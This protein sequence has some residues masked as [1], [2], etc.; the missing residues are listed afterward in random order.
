MPILNY[1]T[2]VNYNKTIGEIQEILVKS[3]ANKIIVDYQQS[4][5]VGL[6]FHI[7]EQSHPIFFSL[8]CNYQGVL[9]S[10]I[11]NPKVPKKLKTEE[12]AMRV[13]W[14]I[15]KDWIQA[16]LA[17]VEAELATVTEVFLP[18]AITKNGVTLYN[19]LKEDK[20]LLLNSPL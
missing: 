14:R 12:Q 16:Q 15:L 6:T 5:P 9:N 19:Y 11:K 17:I 8:P 1:T 2:G 10:L 13:G 7:I 18:Y 3:G 4:L 20:T